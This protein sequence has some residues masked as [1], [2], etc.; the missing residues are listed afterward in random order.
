MLV[1]AGLWASNEVAL[2][3]LNGDGSDACFPIGEIQKIV[4]E[5]D[6]TM[7]VYQVDARQQHFDLSSVQ[8]MAFV[9]TTGTRPDAVV[10]HAPKLLLHPNPVGETLWVV[11]PQEPDVV[12]SIQVYDL[13]GRLAASSIVPPSGSEGH[14][15]VVLPVASL[16]K[17]M[18]ICRVL[19][20]STVRT[21]TFI[22]H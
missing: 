12:A 20:G 22:K 7:V 3:V 18:Y 1:A 13:N 6:E 10:A 15:E 19:M 21:A 14:R 9:I 2:K 17:G 8:K 16:S 11:F 4:F 5:G